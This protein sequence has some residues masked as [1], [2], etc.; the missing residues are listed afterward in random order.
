MVKSTFA[1]YAERVSILVVALIV[2]AWVVL[3]F[4]VD[5]SQEPDSIDQGQSD[6]V[7]DSVESVSGN[8]TAPDQSSDPGDV[9]P[10]DGDTASGGDD[11]AEPSDGAGVGAPGEAGTDGGLPLDGGDSA[12][13]PDGSESDGTQPGQEVETESAGDGSDD[14]EGISAEPDQFATSRSEDIAPEDA[15]T[16]G[17]MP[18]DGS[19]SAETSDGL[20]SERIEDA[21]P[22]PKAETES[23]GDGS[24]DGEGIS[25]EPDQSA[26]SG[27]EAIAPD[28]AGTDGGMLPDGGVSAETSDG[29]ESERTEDARPGPKAETESSGDGSDDGEVVSAEP[30]QSASSGSEGIA[31]D[32]AGTDGGMPPD[33]SASAEISDGLE[34]ERVEDAQPGP[35]AET[36]VSGDGLD[37]GADVSAEP[38]QSASSG[39]E[40]IA[41][42]DAGTDGGMLPDGSAS[43]EISD[44]LESERVEDAQ[45]SPK[46]ETES[47]KAETESSGDGLDGGE[48]VS[49][50][51]DQSRVGSEDGVS[52][53]DGT[54]GSASLDDGASAEISDGLESERVEDAQPSPKAE[55]VS[56]GDG[57]DGGEG[58]GAEPDQSRVG[59]EDGVSDDDGTEGSAALDD[60]ASAV[61]SDGPKADSANGEQ[62]VASTEPLDGID[63]PVQGETAILPT[64]DVVRVDQFKFATIAGRG[65][66][67]WAIDVLINSELKESGTISGDGQFAFVFQLDTEGGPSEITLVS[68][69]G[70]GTIYRSPDTVL[71]LAPEDVEAPESEEIQLASAD[72]L[73]PAVLIATPESVKLKQAPIPDRPAGNPGEN[74]RIDSISYDMDGEVV[75]AGR[76]GAN[77]FIKIYLDNLPVKTEQITYFGTWEISLHGVD[78]GRYMLKLE[79]LDQSENVVASVVTPF[80]KEFQGDALEIIKEAAQASGKSDVLD[81]DDGRIADVVTVQPGYTLWGISRKSFG[82]GRFYVRI[83]HTNIDQIDDPDLI[84]PGQLLVVPNLD[85][86]PPRRPS[87][88]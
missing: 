78:A 27:S 33:G 19:D 38:D 35:K 87:L 20:E 88:N 48:G 18:S 15:G 14:G 36:E 66:P 42:D 11:P 61:D 53:D 54:E 28:D 9:P 24:D 71:I 73:L 17:D 52:D 37:G 65:M 49:A 43:A 13:D 83:Y 75:L 4:F 30:D 41:P 7:D 1:K 80:Q 47:P 57:L 5:D 40:G 58:V 62:L 25:A 79:E 31:P 59:S 8:E 12:E 55:T 77:G 69:D 81:M 34:S 29:L 3:T 26:S 84:F 56:S 64:F 21:Q 32:D 45:P 50:E 39:S 60:G 74:L 63:T 44:G 82:Q 67:N 51:P 2:V 70:D 68:R 23:S 76:G 22:S 6:Q 46:A 16:D 86:T 72:P 85:T 10:A